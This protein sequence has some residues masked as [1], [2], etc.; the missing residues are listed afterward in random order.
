MT[1]KGWRTRADAVRYITEKTGCPLSLRY[2]NNLCAPSCG[3]GPR[4]DAKFH[5]RDLYTEADL[6]AWI[7]ERMEFTAPEAA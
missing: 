6:D 4:V 2:F 7:A 5:G 3:Q 1:G